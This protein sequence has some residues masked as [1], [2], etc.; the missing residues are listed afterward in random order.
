MANYHVVINCTANL[1][2]AN[3]DPALITNAFANDVH[4]PRRLEPI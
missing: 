2:M 1:Y 3:I 4:W